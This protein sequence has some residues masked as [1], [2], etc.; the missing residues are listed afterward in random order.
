MS[1]IHWFFKSV[2]NS[3]GQVFFSTK[4]TFSSLLI[5][6]TFVDFYTGAFGLF[7]VVV[8]NLIAYWLGLNKYKI[9]EGFFGFNSLL[10]GLGLGIYFQPGALL[11]LIVFLAAILTLFISV[12]LEGMIGKYALPYLSIPFVISLWILTLASREFMK[13]GLNER[14]IYTLNDLYIIGGGSLV[15]LYE[16]WNNIPLPS[17][18]RSYFLSLGAILFQY[19][20]FTGV[21]LAVGL[22]TYSRIGFTLSLIGFYTAYLFYMLIGA[23]FSEVH[24]SYIGFNYILSSI[25]LGGFFL[26][27]N[28]NSYLWVVLIVPLVAIVTISLSSILEPY[29]LPV[30]SLP[31]NLVALVFLYVLKFRVNNKANLNPVYIQQ[32]SPE[33]NLYSFLNFKERFGKETP[34]PIHLPFHGEWTVTQGH[35]GEYTHKGSWRHAWDFQ[36]KN[37]EGKTYEDSGDFVGDYY[38]Y[39]KNIVAPA[40]GIIEAIIDD[41]PDNIIGEKNLEYN[42]GN[43]IVI[44]HTEY[45]FSKLSHLKPQSVE[46]KIGQKVEQGD[47]LAKCGNSGNSPYPHLHFQL[48]GTPHIG[49]KTIDYPLS[50]YLKKLDDRL[51][52]MTTAS[53]SRDDVVMNIQVN[54]ALRKAFHLTPGQKFMFELSEPIGANVE[55]EVK[56]DYYL[57][58]YIE[59]DTSKSRAYFKV[60]EAMLYFTHFEGDRK[61]LLYYFY[62]A[63]F[64]VCFGYSKGLRIVDTYPINMVFRP[65]QHFIHDFLAPFI[66][67]MK[68]KYS[69]SYKGAENSLAETQITL[70]ATTYAL[71]FNNER[72]RIITSIHVDGTGLSRIEINHKKRKYFAKRLEYI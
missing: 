49:S 16:W 71:V 13:L 36:I 47:L 52:L 10:V 57:N 53:P 40:M 11:L 21:I 42:W 54:S 61:S 70:N 8:T 2:L 18:I 12:S 5:L 25:A 26:V 14:G 29:F 1:N 67:Y 17:S 66:Q 3:Y 48:Q 38:C 19:N 64:K 32:N 46:V 27:P 45:L 23:K 65:N 34:I 69:L 50:N 58:K 35:N 41:V 51:E 24:Y 72:D 20:L 62:L 7:A 31:F 59:C 15:K 44:K 4:K 55:W 63:A 30:Y 56:I 33:K 9:T 68:G 37:D 22:L 60:D 6:A 43:T 28:R 39:G